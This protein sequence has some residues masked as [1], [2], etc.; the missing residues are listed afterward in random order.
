MHGMENVRLESVLSSSRSSNN[1]GDPRLASTQQNLR[2]Y[3]KFS[4]RQVLDSHYKESG[5]VSS[6]HQRG[7]RFESQIFVVMAGLTRKKQRTASLVNS[8][9]DSC[10]LILSSAPGKLLIPH[11]QFFAW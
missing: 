2:F 1:F 6:K 4:R 10:H 5:N 8:A 3:A 9:K 7:T 11:R